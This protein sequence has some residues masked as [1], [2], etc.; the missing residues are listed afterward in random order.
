MKTVAWMGIALTIPILSWGQSRGIE[1]YKEGKYAE[2]AQ[3]LA[4]EVQQAPDDVEKLSY[5]GLARVYAGDANS[6]MEPLKKAIAKNDKYANAHFGLGLCYV[7]LKNLDQA[8][9]ELERTVELAP[10][11]AYAHYYLGMTYNQKGKK[12]QAVLHLR[13]FVELAPNAPEA[14]AIRAFLS[15][16]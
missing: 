9:S 12:D 15:K 2:A 3:V 8:I 13:R 14:P 10:D 4:T 6:A 11:N 7:K 16:G 1:L 5:L